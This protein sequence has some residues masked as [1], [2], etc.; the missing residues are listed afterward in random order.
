MVYIWDRMLE[1][2]NAE[3]VWLYCQIC[4]CQIDIRQFKIGRCP[5][6]THKPLPIQYSW[7]AINWSNNQEFSVVH[8]FKDR[9]FHCTSALCPR[10]SGYLSRGKLSPKNWSY[11]LFSRVSLSI[12]DFPTVF[13]KFSLFFN[14]SCFQQAISSN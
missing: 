10:H 5:L 9:W 11:C 8:S 6:S 13:P 4:Q 2:T 1:A 7:L 12:P 14:F 3:P